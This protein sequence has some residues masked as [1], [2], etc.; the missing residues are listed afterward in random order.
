[1]WA[2]ASMPGVSHDGFDGYVAFD[3]FAGDSKSYGGHAP[4]QESVGGA[5]ELDAAATLSNLLNSPS[6]SRAAFPQQQQQPTQKDLGSTK[7]SLFD[8]VVK[9]AEARKKRKL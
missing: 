9:G 1:M 6:P 2:Q 5:E 7:R 4:S 8:K 3:G